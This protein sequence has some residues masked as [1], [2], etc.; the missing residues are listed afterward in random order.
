MKIAAWYIVGV[1]CG[2]E[3]TVFFQKGSGE[4]SLLTEIILEPLRFLEGATFFV[5]SFLIFSYT[6]RYGIKLYLKLAQNGKR[7][8]IVY[9]MIDGGILI[10]SWLFLFYHGFWVTLVLAC[11]TCVH[12][13]LSFEKT[14]RDT[15]FER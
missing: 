6:I 12:L 14:Q 4:T 9:G 5:V 15:Y 7:Q 10:I 11:F 2:Y 8:A 3:A 1:L 13:G